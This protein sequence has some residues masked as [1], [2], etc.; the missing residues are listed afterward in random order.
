MRQIRIGALLALSIAAYAQ[1]QTPEMTKILTTASQS[2]AAMQFDTN[3]PVT[4]KGPRVHAGM[5]ARDK[6]N[7]GDRG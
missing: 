2:L 5:A 4:V 6:R 3:S 7:G 1:V